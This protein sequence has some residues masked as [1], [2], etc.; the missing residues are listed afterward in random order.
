MR[1]VRTV[2]YSEVLFLHLPR[3]LEENHENTSVR[4]TTRGSLRY[5]ATSQMVEDS[6][7]DDVI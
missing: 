4:V 1:K 5:Y 7:P 2:A 3:A 6:F